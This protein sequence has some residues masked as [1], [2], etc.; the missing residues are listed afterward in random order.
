VTQ[1]AVDRPHLSQVSRSCSR[2][3]R[4]EKENEGRRKRRAQ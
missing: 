1:I 4:L 2:S 3:K